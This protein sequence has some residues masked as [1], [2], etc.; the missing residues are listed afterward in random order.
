MDKAAVTVTIE[1]P[2]PAY[3]LPRVWGWTVES[4]RQVADDF[5]V[6]TLEAF[7]NEWEAA[8]AAGRSTWGVWRDKELGGV[9]TSAHINP[10]CVDAHCVFKRSF[11]GHDTTVEALRLVFEEIFAE[12]V[13][14]ITA[15]AFH[16]NHA[17]LGLVR[18][19][20]FQKEGVL[21]QQTRRNGEMVDVVLIGLTKAAFG[22]VSAGRPAARHAAPQHSAN[23]DKPGLPVTNVERIGPSRLQLVAPPECG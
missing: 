9:V 22:Q 17:L 4:R 6:S 19:L 8:D 7:V 21:R 5:A 14:K 23:P 12:G 13:V 3:A 1:R 20:G 2:F 15:T 11:W 10:M 16:D 18:K